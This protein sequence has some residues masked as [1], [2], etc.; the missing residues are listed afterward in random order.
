MR[1]MVRELLLMTWIKTMKRKFTLRM[2]MGRNMKTQGLWNPRGFTLVEL[3][4]VT[5]IV[6]ILA[7]V[8][9]PAY[10]NYV[11]RSKQS[12]AAAMLMTARLEMEEFYTDNRRYA[13]T[14]QCLPS[15]VT[16]SSASC[17]SDCS[18]CSNSVKP[19]FYSFSISQ[20][21]TNPPYFKMAATRKIYSWAQTDNLIISASTDTPIVQ[22][23]DA[24]KFSVMK[25][26]FD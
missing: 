1:A 21:G 11:N 26:I 8:A 24:L 5:A 15:F 3:M 19:K 23:T 2:C 6:A 14:I 18:A 4:V 10:I 9:V 22:N 13:S 12:E 16:Q 20:T 25:W 7:S 17:L